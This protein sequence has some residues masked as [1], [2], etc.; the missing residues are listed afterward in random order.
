MR[1]VSRC[2]TQSDGQK[3]PAENAGSF[4]NDNDLPLWG[5]RGTRSGRL[6]G[7][8]RVLAGYYD[9]EADGVVHGAQYDG[10]RRAWQ[11][12]DS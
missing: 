1:W 12:S 8:E 6:E 11:R 4:E 10:R 5:G 7:R 9:E 2:W 3:L